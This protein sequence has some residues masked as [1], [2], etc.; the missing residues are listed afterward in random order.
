MPTY[1]QYSARR[2]RSLIWRFRRAC[3]WRAPARL[4]TG[5]ALANPITCCR[6][7]CVCA[8][9]TRRVYGAAPCPDVAKLASRCPTNCQSRGL[10]RGGD[11]PV[12]QRSRTRSCLMQA[13]MSLRTSAP[14]RRIA[15][16]PVAA[17]I[18]LCAQTVP[19]H[20]QT[21]CWPSWSACAPSPRSGL[22][23]SFL[24]KPSFQNVPDG[25]WTYLQILPRM[26]CWN[27]KRSR[28]PAL[29]RCL[30]VLG[31]AGRGARPATGLTSL[32]LHGMPADVSRRPYLAG[33]SP[34]RDRLLSVCA[35]LVILHDC[36]RGR[37]S[38]RAEA[39]I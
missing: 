13:M 6:W 11:D 2:G 28:T 39:W 7:T 34:R 36:S 19:P 22:F 35:M 32:T 30:H 37:R 33:A 23:H 24:L 14:D 10:A 27:A 1:Q 38:C 9:Q 29:T 25:A 4:S 8:S 15:L 20:G 26:R 3:I 17:D 31:L 21:S 12:A 18:M 5:L 16:T